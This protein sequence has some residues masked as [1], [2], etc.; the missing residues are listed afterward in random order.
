MVN[1]LNDILYSLITLT[2]M[3]DLNCE[4]VSPC[5]VKG[6]L[7]VILLDVSYNREGGKSIPPFLIMQTLYKIEIRFFYLPVHI[8]QAS[9]LTNSFAI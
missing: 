2:A 3:P 4:L 8:V 1:F 5:R 6:Q 9:K 7:P